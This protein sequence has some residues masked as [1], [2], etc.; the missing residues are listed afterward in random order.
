MVV[1]TKF[2]CILLNMINAVLLF[3]RFGRMRL[4]LVYNPENV[5]KLQPLID[6]ILKRQLAM[7][8]ILEWN[9]VKVVYKKYLAVRTS[10]MPV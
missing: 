9:S 4:K 7:C 6:C 10:L 5:V 2:I 3:N 8:N 1:L